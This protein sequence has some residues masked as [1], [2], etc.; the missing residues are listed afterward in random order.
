MAWP[1]PAFTYPRG[2]SD[3]SA[4]GIYVGI[5][6]SQSSSPS[7]WD[8]GLSALL[9]LESVSCNQGKVCEGLRVC[10][11]ARFPLTFPS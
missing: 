5:E 11:K 6:L 9:V 8:G 1:P 10:E 7:T 3:L 4:C 2:L